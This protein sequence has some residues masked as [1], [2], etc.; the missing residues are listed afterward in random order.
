MERKLSPIKLDSYQPLREVVCETL[1]DAI[2]KGT[3][4][5]GERLMEIQLAEEL[6]VS[7]TPVREAIRKLELEGYVIMMP[8]RG[9]YVANLSIR[10]VNEVFEIRTSLDSLASGLAAERIT[11]EELERLQRLLVAIGGYIE[12]NDMEKIVETDTEFHDLLYQASRNSRLVGI[13]FNLREQLT[14]FRATSMA[15]PGRLKATLEEHRRIVEAIAQGDVAEAQAA[16]EYHM[17][18]SEQTLLQSMEQLKKKQE[19]GKKS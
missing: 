1:R 17:E 9:T 5:P 6:G 18:K 16:A 14:R 12:A 3:L 10:D 13:I 11:D 4:K 19:K 15:F 7:R 2:R 8:R